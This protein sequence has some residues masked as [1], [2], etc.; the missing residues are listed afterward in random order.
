VR[1]GAFVGRG[2][3]FFRIELPIGKM[4]EL[5][6]S[7]ALA[8]GLA[9]PPQPHTDEVL[10][11]L[12]A[13]MYVRPMRELRRM[14]REEAY[15]A[16]AEARVVDTAQGSVA[17]WQWGCAD[18]PLVG[19]VHGWEGHA[20]Q[21]GG[22]AAPLVA[23]GF[24]VLAFD[25]PGHGESPGSEAN[26][27]LI[28]RAIVELGVQFGGFFGLVGHSMGAAAA[29]M[30]TTLGVTPAG[31][32]FLAPPLCQTDRVARLVERLQLAPGARTAFITAL[33][34]RTGFRHEDVDMRVAA[35][36]ASFPALLLHD[37]ADRSCPFRNSEMIAA[38][39]PGSSIVPCPGRGHLRIFSTA[40]VHRHTVA[41][42]SALR[43]S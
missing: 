34:R 1:L 19:L 21:L 35:R 3:D 22:F 4:S 43:Q 28:A 25:A 33:E 7:S 27:P 2:L 40:D 38:E 29:A 12:A 30:A 37:P 32:V 24:R 17:T 8:R 23:A 36:R 20:A 10:G 6:L 15:L 18:G 5:L 31:V 26:V 39:W 16:S 11:G 41:F 14:P 13:A 9:L 42:L